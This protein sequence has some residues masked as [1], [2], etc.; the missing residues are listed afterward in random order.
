MRYYKIFSQYY[1]TDLEKVWFADKGDSAWTPVRKPTVTPLTIEKSV[2]SKEINESDLPIDL[3]PM[4]IGYDTQ[5]Y[6]KTMG[7]FYKLRHIANSVDEANEFC[8]K[9]KDCGVIGK[10]NGKSFIATNEECDFEKEEPAT[11]TKLMIRNE[12][13]HKTS[14]LSTTR[15]SQYMEKSTSI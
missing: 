12:S 15:K 10:A 8:K 2:N 6:V 9:N 7:K 14:T 5:I 11:T 4:E 3:R 13:N 1:R